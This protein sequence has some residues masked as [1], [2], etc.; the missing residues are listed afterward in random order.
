MLAL[1]LNI[2]SAAIV[3]LVLCGSL[4]LALQIE[5]LVRGRLFRFMYLQA[6]HH[7]PSIQN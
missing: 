4:M 5:K 2:V 1:L 6:Q 7:Q 3:T